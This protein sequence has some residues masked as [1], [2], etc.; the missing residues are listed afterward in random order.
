[1]YIILVFMA[2]SRLC[3]LIKERVI[4][5]TKGIRYDFHTLNKSAVRCITPLALQASTAFK[6]YLK[7]QDLYLSACAATFHNGVI[8]LH[9]DLV[10]KGINNGLPV[11][12]WY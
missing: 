9:Q 1:M 4:S 3:V 6:Q 10:S 5:P 8:E 7:S 11:V 12:R 2:K